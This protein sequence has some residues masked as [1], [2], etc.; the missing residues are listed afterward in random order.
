MF[1]LCD[2][3]V[4]GYLCLLVCSSQIASVRDPCRRRDE[5]SFVCRR[6]SCGGGEKKEK[7]KRR[8]PKKEEKKKRK[9][10]ERKKKTITGKHNRNRWL[11]CREREA[12]EKQSILEKYGNV[13]P[14]SIYTSEPIHFASEV[15]IDTLWGS[16]SRGSRIHSFL[17]R[18]LLSLVFY[19][20][21]IV[22]CVSALRQGPY[23]QDSIA[24]VY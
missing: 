3:P 13:L 16:T 15:S 12:R 5:S 24:N 10:K 18:A 22:A 11:N 6:L 1:S 20:F 9:G 14:I 4:Y 8:K 19:M 2:D 21:P 7:K 17:P 23:F